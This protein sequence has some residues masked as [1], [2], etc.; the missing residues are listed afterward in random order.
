MN[1]VL[2]GLTSLVLYSWKHNGPNGPPNMKFSPV[3]REQ[4]V[5]SKS[6]GLEK[7]KKKLILR[8][9][10]FSTHLDSLWPPISSTSSGYHFVTPHS[11][12]PFSYRIRDYYSSLLLESGEFEIVRYD[13]SPLWFWIHPFLYLWNYSFVHFLQFTVLREEENNSGKIGR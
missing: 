11:L 5:T 12:L 7:K 1:Y 10:L 6:I 3:P 9:V 2:H 8:K 4:H 13:S